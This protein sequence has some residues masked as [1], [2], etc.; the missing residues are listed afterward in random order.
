M[1]MYTYIILYINNFTLTYVII[2]DINECDKVS[3]YS[4][5]LFP[6]GFIFGDE[7]DMF[8]FDDDPIPIQ[9][10]TGLIFYNTNYTK[11]FV[12]FKFNYQC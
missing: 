10:D 2:T 12:S 1:Y 4:N 3:C 8:I 9:L 11:V 7:S 5:Q 6:F